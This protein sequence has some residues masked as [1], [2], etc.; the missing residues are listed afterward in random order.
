M[1]NLTASV[2]DYYTVNQTVVIGEQDSNVELQAR[3]A[4]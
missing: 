2:F 1:L 3:P 4:Y